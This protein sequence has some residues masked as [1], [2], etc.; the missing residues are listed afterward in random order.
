VGFDW[1]DAAGVWDKIGEETQ[2]LV[3]AAGQEQ[4]HR[5]LGDVLFTWAQWARHGGLKAEAALRAANRRFEQR[6][7]AMEA[8]AAG[9]GRSLADMSPQEREDLWQTV[10]AAEPG[11]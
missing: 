11:S 2:E 9:Q 6:F 8:L 1:P 3:Q 4:A 7:A 10:K 5:E